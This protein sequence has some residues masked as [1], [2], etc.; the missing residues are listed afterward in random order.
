M[1]IFYTHFLQK[2]MVTVAFKRKHTIFV[3]IKLKEGK[4]GK[5]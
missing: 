5:E 1:N 4:E 3:K 2:L